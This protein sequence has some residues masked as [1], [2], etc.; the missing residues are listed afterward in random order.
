MRTLL[1]DGRAVKTNLGANEYPLGD[2]NPTA[3]LKLI[4]KTDSFEPDRDFVLRL[5]REG[6]TRITLRRYATRIRGWYD[7]YALVR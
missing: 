7:I 1:V 3:T 5:A 2:G 4:T 6:Y